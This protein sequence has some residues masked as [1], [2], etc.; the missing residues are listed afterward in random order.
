MTRRRLLTPTNRLVE[1][2]LRCTD[3]GCDY[4]VLRRVPRLVPPEQFTDEER[5]ALAD[6]P[7]GSDP[8]V[9]RDEP[10]PEDV[11]AR[12]EV[13]IRAKTILSDM[14][15]KLRERAERNVQY[16]LHHTESKRKF[17]LTVKPHLS[18]APRRILDLGGGQ[19]GTLKDFKEAFS[20]ETAI[21]LDLDPTWVEVAALRDFECEVIRGDATRLPLAAEAIDLLVSTATLEHIPDWRAAVREVA[22][23]AQR[24]LICYGPNGRFPYD[25]GHLD[26]PFVTWLNPEAASRVALLYHRMRRTGRTAESIRGELAVTFFIPRAAVVR[27]LRSLGLEVRNVFAEFLEHSV[28]ESYH[29]AAA[30]LMKTLRRA[31][32][33]RTI[34][35][36]GLTFL[37]AE[38]NVYLLTG[39][40]ERTSGPSGDR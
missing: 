9:L 24:A 33:V 34:F 37:G 27:E 25:F 32:W 14:S 3:C 4:P 17:V 29:F 23:T 30:G 5:S 16:L 10:S 31:P 38:P 39:P 28:N 19:G 13:M 7:S 15:P 20:P 1:G 36:K 26:A 18:R 8:E 22:R 2:F 11:Q 21:L 12:I 40:R 35:A 6:T